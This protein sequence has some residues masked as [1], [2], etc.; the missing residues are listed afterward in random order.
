MHIVAVNV[1]CPGNDVFGMTELLGF[2]AELYAVNR[3]QASLAR[4][5]AD[6]TVQLR[7][8]QPPPQRRRSYGP[9]ASPTADEKSAGPSTRHLALP[10][11]PRRNPAGSPHCQTRQRSGESASRSPREPRPPKKLSR[12]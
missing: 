8:A 6:R 2:G 7:S 3:L 11:F 4:R 5:R 9:A 1:R 10:V 12:G